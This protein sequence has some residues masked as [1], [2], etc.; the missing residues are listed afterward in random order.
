MVYRTT[1]DTRARKDAKRRHLVATAA[2]VFAA[3]GYAATTVKDI[4]DQAEVAV[5]TF[6]LYFK[7]KEDMLASLFEEMSELSAGAVDRAT[8]GPDHTIVQRFA[9]ATAASLATYQEYRDLTRILFIEAPGINPRFQHKHLDRMERSRKRMEEILGHLQRKGLIATDDVTL[10]ALAFDG[11]FINVIVDWLHHRKAPPLTDSAEALT[12][13][14][15]QALGITYTREEVR[16]AIAEYLRAPP[17]A[18]DE[19]FTVTRRKQ[20]EP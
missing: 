6:Y 17:P 7:S 19:P 16:R 5:G 9:R 14:N 1:A 3:R 20:G 11:T 18:E 13:Y 2:R 12:I 10:A 8:G 15:L 4:A